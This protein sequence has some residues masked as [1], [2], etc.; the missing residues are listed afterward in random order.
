ML[1]LRILQNVSIEI[2]F[3]TAYGLK[4]GNTKRR[5]LICVLSTGRQLVGICRCAN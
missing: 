3:S 4:T 2:G 1:A 5:A